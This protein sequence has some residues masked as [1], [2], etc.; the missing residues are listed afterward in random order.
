MYMKDLLFLSVS[1]RSV[2]G[3]ISGPYSRLLYSTL[4]AIVVLVAKIFCDLS[5]SFLNFLSK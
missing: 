3:Q 2:V 4:K 1:T 5:P